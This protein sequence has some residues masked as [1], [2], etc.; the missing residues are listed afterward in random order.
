[1]LKKVYSF[2]FYKTRPNLTDREEAYAYD[3]I[4]L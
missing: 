1:M 3:E 4:L 2:L